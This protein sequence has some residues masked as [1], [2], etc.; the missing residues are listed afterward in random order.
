MIILRH[1]FLG[2]IFILI[3][4]SIIRYMYKNPDLYR[5]LTYNKVG[6]YG[7]GAALI[8]IGVLEFFG[9]INWHW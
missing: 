3:G 6:I 9:C 7:F 4:I 2:I 8:F 5:T 1:I